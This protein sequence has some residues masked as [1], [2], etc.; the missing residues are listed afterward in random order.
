MEN[1]ENPLVHP[2]ILNSFVFFSFCSLSLLLSLQALWR[3]HRSRRLNDDAKLQKIRHRLRK[4]SAG[5]QE[6]DKLCNKTSSALDYLLRY[7]HFSYILEALR[8]LGKSSL[9]SLPSL[10]AISLYTFVR[11]LR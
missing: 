9:V 4:V 5:V 11:V 1:R 3:G 7:K 10:L 2:R 8:K 6:E